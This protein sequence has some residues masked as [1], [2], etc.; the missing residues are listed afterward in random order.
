MPD[1]LGDIKIGTLCAEIDLDTTK[2]ETNATE[3]ERTY[4]KLCRSIKAQESIFAK[5]SNVIYN[6]GNKIK[7]LE[8][9]YKSLSDAQKSSKEGGDIQNEIEAKREKYAELCKEIDVLAQSL[10]KTEDKAKEFEIIIGQQK[11]AENMKKEISE[12]KANASAFVSVLDTIDTA[13]GGASS[14]IS[15]II[16]QIISYKE[17]MSAA[18]NA[19]MSLSQGLGMVGI[20]ISAGAFIYNTAKN[21]IEEYNRKQLESIKQARESADAVKKENDS[22]ND[23][24]EHVKE[25]KEKLSSGEL[26]LSEQKDVRAELLGIQDEWLDNLDIEAGKVNILS[27]SYDGLKSS[28]EEAEKKK[29]D[30]TYQEGYSGY[31]AAE[32]EAYKKYDATSQN[33]SD[34]KFPREKIDWENYGWELTDNTIVGNA[35]YYS[36]SFKGT[37]KGYVESLE[38]IRKDIR[39]GVIELGSEKDRVLNEIEKK[40]LYVQREKYK[41]A[42]DTVE[43]FQ[44]IVAEHKNPYLYEELNNAIDEYKDA[45][46]NQDYDKIDEVNALFEK[47]ASNWQ[48][49]IN[50]I[51]D[52]GAKEYL[53][54]LFDQ[55]KENAE[56]TTAGLWELKRKGII[57]EEEFENSLSS[58]EAY[59]DSL[60]KGMTDVGEA[61]DYFSDCLEK[62]NKHESLSEEE[63]N[64][65]I[66]LYPELK[67]NII[68]TANGWTV[69][70]S[71]LKDI[72]E[73]VQELKTA[74]T[75][76]QEN[77]TNVVKT[78]AL[79]RLGILDDEL[80]GI[81][82]MNQAYAI[83]KRQKFIGPV[84]EGYEFHGDESIVETDDDRAFVDVVR[85]LLELKSKK[86]EFEKK[87][88]ASALG[89][90]DSRKA[91]EAKRKAE[92]AKRKAEE[93]LKELAGNVDN[94]YNSLQN[95]L[96]EKY[97]SI[98]ESQKE[99]IQKSIDGWKEWADKSTEAVQAQIDALDELEKK[100]ENENKIAELKRK[101]DEIEYQLRFETDEYNRKQLQKSLNEA[102][103]NL[104]D[105]IKAQE[106]EQL[107]SDLQAQMEEIQK[108][109]EE[110]QNSLNDQIKALDE[111]YKNQTED[112]AI[113][114]E[115]KKMI[116]NRQQEEIIGLLKQYEP[117]YFDLGKSFGEQLI[118][119]FGKT[120]I[121]QIVS[122]IQQYGKNTMD[123]IARIAS[124]QAESY[125]M[126]MAGGITAPTTNEINIVCN[127]YEKTDSPSE[128]KRN[129]DSVADY[130]ASLI[131]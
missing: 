36:V 123:T 90:D 48:E 103:A 45:L 51:Q 119:G 15:N 77:M 13:T 106:R 111:A 47:N 88:N 108:I 129:M 32:K 10:D 27:D 95:A 78:G 11:A 83:L 96:K 89:E 73:E 42:S 112:A 114:N 125:N 41:E 2:L 3:A 121:G 130:L 99:L 118:E 58:L 12:S 17:A 40:L 86:E 74:Y 57:T 126:A 23:Q 5:Q 62:V 8:E 60:Q 80:L 81:Q 127:F 131:R 18:G 33:I 69:E 70:Q 102:K 16:R 35:R 4:A 39:D 21:A 82:S 85:A 49:K 110:K 19:G 66:K 52:K 63:K 55:I 7:E 91:E 124:Q 22:I 68:K 116:L 120:S 6:L 104:E 54:G 20:A 109:S 128:I 76:A 101:R 71:A 98:Y 1:S 24:L 53:Q 87:I 38:Q 43:G 30:K 34:L 65:L 72:S 113:K 31:K 64:R 97:K 56:S 100:E 107:R 115:A 75:N 50:V 93:E 122:G 84:Q 94:I 79:K 28:I 67:D 92:E 61:S 14:G 9:S 29:R 59:T 37:K 46:I 26:S 25:L 117:D 105:E 44:D